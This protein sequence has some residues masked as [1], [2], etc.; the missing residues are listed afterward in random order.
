MEIAAKSS[1]VELVRAKRWAGTARDWDLARELDVCK[2]TRDSFQRQIGLL[3][4]DND[5]SNYNSLT[6]RNNMNQQRIDVIEN[7]INKRRGR[8]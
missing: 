8:F 5:Q 7:E 2:Q 6:S 1:E 4:I 3:N